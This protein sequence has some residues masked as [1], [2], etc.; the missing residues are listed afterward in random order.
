MDFFEIFTSGRYHRDM[1]ALKILAPNSKHFRIHGTFNKWKLVCLGLNTTFS[2]ITVS[3][4]LWSWKFT[5]VCF[6]TQKIQK[7]HRNWPKTYCPY[8]NVPMTVIKF[9]I[10][11]KFVEFLIKK[12]F[13]S[14]SAKT[15]VTQMHNSFV[16]LR[17]VNGLLHQVLACRLPVHCID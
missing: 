12:F 14:C 10:I 9:L 8:R 6:F 5:G 17:V 13:Q 4:N 16:A 1:K 7:W 15:R 2:L 11:F 3:N